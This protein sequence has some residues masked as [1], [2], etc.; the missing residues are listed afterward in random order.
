MLV[1]E[2]EALTRKAVEKALEGDIAALKLCLDRIAP[3]LRPTAMTIDIQI[4]AEATLT[5]T[6]RAFV[7]AAAAGEL[8]PDIAAQLVTAVAGV[9][10][11]EE[12]ESIKDRLEALERA[13]KGGRN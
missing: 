12:L 1:G 2:L 8:P 13:L 9:A 7:S 5:D 11:V 4:P 6:A 3:P 10:K